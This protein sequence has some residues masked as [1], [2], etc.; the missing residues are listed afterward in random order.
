VSAVVDPVGRVIAKS[1]TFQQETL[2]ATI[3]WMRSRTVYEILG[4][5][6][7]LLVSVVILAGCFVTRRQRAV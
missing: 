4:D 2:S 5:W 7:W 6:P 3:H 1:G